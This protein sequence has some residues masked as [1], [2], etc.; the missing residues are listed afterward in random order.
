MV[1]SDASTAVLLGPFVASDLVHVD[2]QRFVQGDN[3]AGEEEE[4]GVASV[5]VA[6]QRARA[7]SREIPFEAKLRVE[8]GFGSM[9][10]FRRGAVKIAERVVE[11]TVALQTEGAGRIVTASRATS[12]LRG[13]VDD[14]DLGPGIVWRVEGGR[15]RQGER[16]GDGN[17]EQG[18]HRSKV[19]FET[20]A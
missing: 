18:K 2:L 7:G 6:R 10:V 19:H 11:V 4:V 14:G 1:D 17:G 20:R 9:V 15:C 16:A 12:G 13:V 5:D 3:L 8:A